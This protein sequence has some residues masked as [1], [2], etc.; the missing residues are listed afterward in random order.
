MADYD[1]YLASHPANPDNWEDPEYEAYVVVKGAT[2]TEWEF[3]SRSKAIEFA[4]A[5]AESEK[6][7]VFYIWFHQRWTPDGEVEKMNDTCFWWNE[8]ERKVVEGE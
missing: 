3:D 1:D 7:F 4:R 2:E 6:D 8:D 5:K